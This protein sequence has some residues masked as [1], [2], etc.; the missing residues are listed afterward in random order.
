MLMSTVENTQVILGKIPIESN[1]Q[2]KG[3]SEFKQNR[4]I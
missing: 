2:Q 1:R 3:N 4:L